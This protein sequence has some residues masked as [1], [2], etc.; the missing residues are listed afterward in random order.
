M[1]AGVNAWRSRGAHAKEPHSLSAVR[2]C[3]DGSVIS[4]DGTTLIAFDLATQNP[5]ET[6]RDDCHPTNTASKD[7]ELLAGVRRLS[8][9]C[10][11]IVARHLSDIAVAGHLNVGEVDRF[12][13]WKCLAP[14]LES[15]T[16]V[17]GWSVRWMQHGVFCVERRPTR[18][19]AGANQLHDGGEHLFKCARHLPLRVPVPIVL[20]AVPPVACQKG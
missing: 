20:M 4:S 15:C 3:V 7:A 18:P 6:H 14:L 13:R 5:I 17:H 2:G 12:H 8:L 11:R 1:Q 9:Y 16:T 19:I 10:E